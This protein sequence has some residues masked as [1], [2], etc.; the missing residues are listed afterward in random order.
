MEVPR[1]AGGYRRHW[2]VEGL[3]E[4]WFMKDNLYQ[5][6]FTEEETISSRNSIKNK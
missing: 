1:K 3:K 5:V 2:L 6:L 4:N